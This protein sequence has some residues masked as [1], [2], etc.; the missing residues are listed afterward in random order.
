MNLIAPTQVES[1]LR[2]P[3]QIPD[4][5]RIQIV[6]D[7]DFD[8]KQLKEKFLKEG[9]TSECAKTVSEGCDAARSGRYQVVV[10]TPVLGDGSWRRLIDIAKYYDLGFETILWASN[11][12][13]SEWANALNEGAFDVLDAVREGPKVV[14]ATKRA[15]WAAYLKGAGPRPRANL[16]PRNAA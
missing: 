16:P 14:E 13:L 12:D 11:F 5:A 6:C 2:K 3:L 9:L 8:T 7:N 4:G 1:G 10:S 15:L